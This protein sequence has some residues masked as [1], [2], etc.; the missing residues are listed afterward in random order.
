[1]KQEMMKWFYFIVGIYC[2]FLIACTNNE[3]NE[4][5]QLTNAVQLNPRAVEGEAL[6]K[7]HCVTCHTLRYI[8][9]QPAFSRKTWEKITE[10]MI[11]GF[12]A[13]IADSS[14][15]LIVDYLTAIKGIRE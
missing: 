1:M 14:A 2:T 10:K 9:M 5:D 3:S 6:Y 4:K 8:E 12:G 13:P 7:I 11:K 15:V